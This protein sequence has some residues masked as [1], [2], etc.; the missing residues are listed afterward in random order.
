MPW[1]RNKPPPRQPPKFEIDLPEKA[2]GILEPHRYKV[3]YGGRAGMKSHTMARALLVQTSEQRL[4]VLCTREFQTSIAESVHR[5][6]A[7][8]IANLKFDAYFDI[9][10]NTIIQ[11]K[12]GSHF[13]FKGLKHNI[14]EIKSTEGVDRC[15]VE[16]AQSVSEESWQVLEPTIR[17]P[18]SE[19]WISFNPYQEIDP[20]YQRFVLNTPTDTWRCKLSWRD[21]PWLS[22]ESEELREFTLR[23]DPDAYDWI[24]E[25]FC[26]K[27]SEAAIFRGRYDIEP[28]ETPETEINR[29]FFGADW[30]F[31]NDPT[32]LVRCW[33][34]DDVLYIDH[35]AYAVGVEIDDTPALFA[36]GLAHKTG[37]LYEGI[38][39]ARDWPIFGDPARPETISYMARRGFAIHP[40][41]KWPG[42]V[43]DG[44]AHL[45]GFSRIKIHPRC[46]NTA[47][48]FRLYSYKVD[49]Q[50][51]KIILPTIED[52]WNHAIDALRYALNGYIQRRGALGQWARL[53]S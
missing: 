17:N 30:G 53:A 28:F 12:T 44:I 22:R 1:G 26:R 19:I 24:W 18:G 48:E 45:K 7:D 3:L 5:T 37:V 36:G 34:R 51:P 4:R 33:I 9:Q 46:E 31:S 35:E 50:N 40:A 13:I 14:Q 49:K 47:Q 25:G 41:D 42:C 32:A 29:F 10:K 39:G 8:E 52:R 21:N 38:P 6:L 27:Q 15:W 11:K 2:L 23:T 43:E 20:T 16:E